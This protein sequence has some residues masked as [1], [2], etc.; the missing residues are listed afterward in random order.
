MSPDDDRGGL[1][2]GWI[3]GE[4]KVQEA[5]GD[6]GAELRLWLRLLTCSTLVETEIRRRLREKFDCTLPRFDLMAQL[7]RARD[8]MVLGELSKRMMVSPGN[9]TAL[10]ERLVES[11]HISRT[12]S[13]ADRRVQIIAL[14]PFGRAEFKTMADAHAEWVAELFGDLSSKDSEALLE[15]LG[16]LKRSVVEA[17]G[18]E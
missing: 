14:T 8:G 17:L 5:P 3:D 1:S 18:R 13:P 10:V 16:K 7:E 6:H 12:A 2:P 4:T 11:G 15:R 9:M